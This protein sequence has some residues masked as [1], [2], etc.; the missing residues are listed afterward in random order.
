MSC[1]GRG[2]AWRGVA[3]SAVAAVTASPSPIRHARF[4]VELSL[5]ISN[6]K[7]D[8]LFRGL[9]TLRLTPTYFC[10]LLRMSFC[11]AWVR[12]VTFHL[13]TIVRSLLPSPPLSLVR[14]A[15]TMLRGCCGAGAGGCDWCAESDGAAR[16][17]TPRLP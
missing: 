15:P 4:Q 8:R 1:L 5:L 17:D 3:W 10:D 2:V 16:S 14:G 11:S 12:L 9:R 7:P 13:R 6:A